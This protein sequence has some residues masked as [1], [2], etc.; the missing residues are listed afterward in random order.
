M[1]ADNVFAFAWAALLILT[2]AAIASI[3]FFFL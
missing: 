2:A 3:P 1:T